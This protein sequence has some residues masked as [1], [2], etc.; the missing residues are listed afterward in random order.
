MD[1]RLTVSAVLFF[2]VVYLLLELLRRIFFSRLEKVKQH[3]FSLKKNLQDQERQQQ[4]LYNIST[5]VF[6]LDSKEKIINNALS[7]IETMYEWSGITFFPAKSVGLSQ[8]YYGQPLEK[9]KDEVFALVKEGIETSELKV[10]DEILRVGVFPVGH[11]G[12]FLGALYVN[13]KDLLTKE[14]VYFFKTIA[15]FLTI[16]IENV[17]N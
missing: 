7:E 17:E 2:S 11:K 10:G 12:R 1:L 4:V 5:S 3:S 13:N 14:Q 9:G 6:L 8:E 16:A 15:S